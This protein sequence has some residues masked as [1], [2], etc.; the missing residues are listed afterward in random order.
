[1]RPTSQP[2]RTAPPRWEFDATALFKKS[3]AKAVQHRKD[4]FSRPAGH[5]SKKSPLAGARGGVVPQPPHWVGRS[6]GTR[7]ATTCSRRT[8]RWGRVVLGGPS[9]RDGAENLR[10]RPRHHRSQTRKLLRRYTPRFPRDRPEAGPGAPTGRGRAH[11]LRIQAPAQGR[12][13]PLG[14]IHDR[15]DRERDRSVSSDGRNRHRSDYY[16]SGP[17]RACSVT[18]QLINRQASGRAATRTTAIRRHQDR[19]ADN[20]PVT[21]EH[22]PAQLPFATTLRARSYGNEENE[23]NCQREN[24][25]REPRPTTKRSWGD[26]RKNRRMRSCR[27][28]SS[29]D[30]VQVLE[31]DRLGRGC[32]F[33]R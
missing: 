5:F 27:I 2:I 22:A 3:C 24:G 9:G 32:L 28:G 29:E 18:Q 13:G 26:C 19:F 30:A 31:F 20:E 7:T 33:G 11:A 16:S 25:Q 12:R 23:E 10:R 21:I 8:A 6:S 15:R 17:N 4:T 1:M 14:R